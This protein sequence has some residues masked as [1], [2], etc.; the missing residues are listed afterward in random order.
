MRFNFRP[1]SV[2]GGYFWEDCS[3]FNCFN[4]VSRKWQASK[5]QKFICEGINS[6]DV[7][8]KYLIS[9]M[10]IIKQLKINIKGLFCKLLSRCTWKIY[11]YKYIDSLTLLNNMA[12]LTGQRG[13]FQGF[14]IPQNEL[15]GYLV[16]FEKDPSI[17][18]VLHMIVRIVG[19][20]SGTSGHLS[21]CIDL[22]SFWRH[23]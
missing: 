8:R 15:H 4:F 5:N 7:L 17:I 14:K 1:G 21:L 10:H 23:F 19:Y 12:S 16:A 2:K 18:I 3:F 11:L 22:S 9:V 20:I 13:V 6:K